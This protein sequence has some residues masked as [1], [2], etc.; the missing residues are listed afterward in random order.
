MCGVYMNACFV[1]CDVYTATTE[2]RQNFTEGII[3]FI[4][5]L[6]RSRPENGVVVMSVEHRMEHLLLLKYCAVLR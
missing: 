3:F 4:S 5:S 1:L 6:E 2:E